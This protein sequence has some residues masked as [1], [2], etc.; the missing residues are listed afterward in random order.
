MRLKFFF[1]RIVYKIPVVSDYFKIRE[2]HPAGLT[3]LRFCKFRFFKLNKTIYWPCDKDC[4]VTGAAN[5]TIGKN[6]S[7]GSRGC[8][9]QG[10]GKL[11]F[12]D[13]VSVAMNVG[14]MSGNHDI[15]DHSKHIKKITFIGDY[16]WIGMNSIIL[17]G[18]N[19]GPRTVVAAGSVVTKSFPDGFCVLAG[20]PAKIVKEIDRSHFIPPCNEYEYYGYV[21]VNKF[22]K[23]HKKHLMSN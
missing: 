18:V 7:I 5:I 3:F 2:Y 22:H 21:A 16:S 1:K 8:Y 12:G 4:V 9:I 10:V 14:I 23:F 15:L 19:L 13:Y 6:C 17:P 20:N 11:I